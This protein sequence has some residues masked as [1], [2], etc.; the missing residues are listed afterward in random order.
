[1]DRPEPKPPQQPPAGLTRQVW[2]QTV[3]LILGGLSLV[4][5]LAWNDAVISL[6]KEL[7][8][9]TNGSLIA[10]FSYAVVVTVVIVIVSVRLRRLNES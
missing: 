7:F 8:P 2:Q 9:E 1:M 10:K 6:F 5:A 3:S 4:A